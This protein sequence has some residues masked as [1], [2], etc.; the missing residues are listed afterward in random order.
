MQNRYT[1]DIGDFGKYGLLRALCGGN[2]TQP[3]LSL[4]VAWY[5]T[6]DERHNADG[7]HLGYLLSDRSEFRLCDPDLYDEI[8]RLLIDET[9]SPIPDRRRVATV[10]Q[11]GILPRGTCFHSQPLAFARGT[12]RDQLGMRLAIRDA[13][14]REALETTAGKS[15]V[16]LDPDNGIECASVGRLAS[17]GPKY[18]YWTDIDAFVSR[19]QSVV[20]YHH[21]NRSSRATDQVR[22]LVEESRRRMP[23]GTDVSTVLFRRGTCRA[24]V[25][26]AA[27]AHREAMRSRVQELLAGPWN[28]HFE[29]A[30]GI[31]PTERTHKC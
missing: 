4:G 20:V 25:I 18:A 30:E 24:Y 8:R 13:W 5:L 2:A 3:E 28:R 31:E 15:I 1:F 12:S 23:D 19:G 26:A 6:P 27:P 29:A 9:G 17:K 10:E 22:R 21:L 16:F 11:S 7:K 14:L